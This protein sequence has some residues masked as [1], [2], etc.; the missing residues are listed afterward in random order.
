MKIEIKNGMANVYTPYNSDFVKAIKGIG[1]A[2][3]NG[4]GKYWSVPESAVGAVR[5]IMINVYGYSD[6]LKN[7]SISLKIIFNEDASECRKDVMLFGKILAHACDRD[8]GARVGDDVAFILGGVTSGGSAKNWTSIVKEG[9]IAILSNVNKTIYEKTK[10]ELEYDVTVEVL[11]AKINK[12]KLL[13]EKERL[14]KRISE[15]DKLLCE[16]I[17]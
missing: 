16:E 14:L 5:E 11:E 15:I 17:I 10:S 2:K 3:W 12:E 9:S 7:E 1:G 4:D 8:N 6:I 13:E